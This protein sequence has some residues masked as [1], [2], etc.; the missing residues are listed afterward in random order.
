ML[1]LLEWNFIVLVP[2]LYC[3]LNHALW[4]LQPILQHCFKYQMLHFQSSSLLEIYIYNCQILGSRHPCDRPG[5][6]PSCQLSPGPDLSIWKVNHKIKLDVSL[7]ISV[8]LSSISVTLPLKYVNKWTLRNEIVP[9]LKY[10]LYLQST[11]GVWG[12]PWW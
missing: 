1:K 2:T 4:H 5:G 7:Y 10:C 9:F 8:F 11:L 3:R 12:K 6:I